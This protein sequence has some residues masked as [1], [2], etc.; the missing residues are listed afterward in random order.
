VL[1][2]DAVKHARPAE[3]PFPAAVKA[4]AEQAGA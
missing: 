3:A 2:R 4:P 1:V